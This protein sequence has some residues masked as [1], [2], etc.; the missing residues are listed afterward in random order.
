MS[1]LRLDDADKLRIEATSQKALD[2]EPR[3][4][5]VARLDGD[6]DNDGIATPYTGLLVEGLDNLTPERAGAIRKAA[7]DLGGRRLV[8]GNLATRFAHTTCDNIQGPRARPCSDPI[9]LS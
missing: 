4:V 6:P 1:T 3:F 7:V 8:K 2:L 5:C 9:G